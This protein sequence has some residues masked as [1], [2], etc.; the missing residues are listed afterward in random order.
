MQQREGG[1][2]IRPPLILGHFALAAIGL[3][4][5]FVY[6]V[7]GSE[8][9]AWIAFAL[10]LVVALLGFV[11]FGIWAGRRRAGDTA[12]SRFPCR[13]SGST[14]CWRRPRSCSC[15]SP[16][17]G[18]EPE[19]APGA[20]LPTNLPPTARPGPACSSVGPTP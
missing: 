10:L 14:A 8:T 19:S 3:V 9:L 12:E 2:R 1:G 17:P 16:Q 20:R 4:L 18:S 15:S 7:N 13:S 6:L 5:W 11:M